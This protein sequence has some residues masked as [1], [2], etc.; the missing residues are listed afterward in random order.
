MGYKH[1][2]AFP[3]L[4]KNLHVPQGL[5]GFVLGRTP[6]SGHEFLGLHAQCGLHDLHNGFLQGL[7]PPKCIAGTMVIVG[8]VCVVIFAALACLISPMLADPRFGGLFKFIQE[9]QGFISPGNPLGLPHRPSDEAG[10]RL[11]RRDGTARRT[12]GLR[13]S[14][15]LRRFDELSQPD[16]HYPRRRDGPD[17]PLHL[18]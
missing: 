10:P 18:G 4:L 16:G 8:R 17:G 2:A 9:F 7:H 14:D 6:G 3:L 13:H 1:D 15:V 11:Q 5:R 12:A